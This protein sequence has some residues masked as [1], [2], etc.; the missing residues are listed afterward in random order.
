MAQAKH[1]AGCGSQQ[2]KPTSLWTHSPQAEPMC[3]SGIGKVSTI[4][5]RQHACTAPIVNQDVGRMLYQDLG[6]GIPALMAKSTAYM[7]MTAK[8]S[9]AVFA[10]TLVSASPRGPDIPKQAFCPHTRA[11][12]VTTK[13][14][15]SD[16]Q[17]MMR[18]HTATMTEPTIMY[19]RR[20]PHLRVDLSD[21]V[22]MIG[23]TINPDSGGAMKTR[24]VCVLARPS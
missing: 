13:P 5:L 21:I 1:P 15:I 17:P 19:G 7:Q 24:D 10:Y 6:R 23:C 16:A 3:W 11:S 2:A 8:V 18:K 12:S 4:K 14:M 22:P 9:I 20:R